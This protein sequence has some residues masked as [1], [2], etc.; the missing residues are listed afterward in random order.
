MKKTPG[1]YLELDYLIRTR[2][3]TMMKNR[4]EIN[5]GEFKNKVNKAGNTEF[6]HPEYI[7]GTL[8]KGFEIYASIS[9]PV[10]KAIFISYLISEVH[11]FNDGN[12]RLCRIMFNSELAKAK[13][14][15]MIIPTVFREDYL[16]S[17]RALSRRER[18]KSLIR[19]FDRAIGFSNISCTDYVK[20]L[21]HISENNWFLEPN[22]GKIIF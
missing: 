2:H 22:E 7:N 3:L 19:M 5:P 10:A 9:D 4:P 12:G 14:S 20:A 11:P 13:L 21:S 8:Q 6:V 1:S 18:P 17:L 16:L 15:T